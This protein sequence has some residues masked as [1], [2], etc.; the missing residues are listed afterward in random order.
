MPVRTSNLENEML[1][2]LVGAAMASRVTFS[3]PEV[4]NSPWGQVSGATADQF[5]AADF[6]FIGTVQNYTSYKLKVGKSAWR[7]HSDLDIKV[8]RKIRGAFGST[9]VVTVPGG[10]LNGVVTVAPSH[11]P[12]HTPGERYMLAVEKLDAATSIYPQGAVLVQAVGWIDPTIGLNSTSY[13][14]NKVQ[15]FCNAG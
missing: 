8:E 4:V 5:C 3:E 7:V 13:I 12:R 15:G 9:Q 11:Y 10:Q 1:L 14:R 2:F 6:I